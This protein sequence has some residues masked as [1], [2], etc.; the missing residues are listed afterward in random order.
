MF[1]ALWAFDCDIR[2]GNGRDLT[3]C[4]GVFNSLT[5]ETDYIMANHV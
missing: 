2:E 3:G 1:R 5:D 4:L